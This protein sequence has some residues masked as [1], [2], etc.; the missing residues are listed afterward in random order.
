MPV[1][2]RREPA[3]YVSIED[4]SY[5]AE[6]LETG[7]VGYIVTLCDRGPHNRVVTLTS[8]E[9]FYKLFGQPNYRR[10][11]QAHYLADKF[12]QYS[13]NLLLV[14]AMPDDAYWANGEIST[15]TTTV[16]ISNATFKFTANSKIVTATDSTSYNAVNVGTW[17]VSATDA[18]DI[19]KA[20]QVVAKT[21]E[22]GPTYT[23]TLSAPY[24]GTTSQ[25]AEAAHS[26]SPYIA[27]SITSITSEAQ[28]PED[29]ST[30]VWYFY[31]KGAGTYYNNIKIMGVRNVELEKM[32][33]DT[34]GVVLYKYLFMD[35][36]VYYLN[37]DGTTTLL[38]GPWSV[39]LT[40]RNAS[41]SAIRDLT[42]GNSLYIEDIINNNSNF[43]GCIS[44]QAVDGLVA[45]G[46]T[47]AQATKRRLQVQLLM[48]V[49]GSTVDSSTGSIAAGGLQFENGTDGTVNTAR[50]LPMYNSANNLEADR[51]YLN[52]QISLA[53]QGA[54]V[55]VDG[56]IEQLPECVYPWVISGAYISNDIMK[57]LLI[58]GNP[59]EFNYYNAA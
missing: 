4:A 47:E 8:R 23:L 33:T 50:S 35:I 37:D 17:I 2:D 53:Y 14:R 45:V 43:V 26:C 28:M 9:Q 44:A 56:S 24:S 15:S 34:N 31:A 49:S 27:S 6:A 55:S 10:T 59:L 52:G 18:A 29:T 41:G 21:T 57:I 39:S 54:M 51:D 36:G 42:S 11:S 48:T 20:E 30:V 3:V 16:V 25:S 13:S 7:R 58:A 38:E 32:Y 1:T 5:A 22:T 19:E 40:R 12:L 46:P